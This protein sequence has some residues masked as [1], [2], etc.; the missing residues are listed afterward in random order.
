MYKRTLREQYV[1]EFSRPMTQ[2]AATESIDAFVNEVARC[3]EKM[4]PDRGY[5]LYKEQNN[6]ML[7]AIV[8]FDIDNFNAELL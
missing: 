8:V 5:N 1:Y 6:D 3:A 2:C 7:S 4:F